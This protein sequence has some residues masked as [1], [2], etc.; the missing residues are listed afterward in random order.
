MAIKVWEIQQF[1]HLWEWKNTFM[2]RNSKLKLLSKSSRL[3]R[4]INEKF[5]RG[6]AG[7]MSEGVLLKPQWTFGV[8]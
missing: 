1:I 8:S 3:L 2:A 7:V 6:F 4:D 5:T